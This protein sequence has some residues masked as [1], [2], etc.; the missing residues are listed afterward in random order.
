[1]IMSLKS[2][3]S[4]Q[5]KPPRPLATLMLILKHHTGSHGTGKAS[6]ISRVK[7]QTEGPN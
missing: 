7:R 3:L 4:F 2:H 1:M 6:F 5:K